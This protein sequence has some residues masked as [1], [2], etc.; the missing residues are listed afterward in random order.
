MRLRNTKALLVIIGAFSLA[1]AWLLVA[2][3][4][5]LKLTANPVGQLGA[6]I[7]M[8]ILLPSVIATLWFDYRDQKEER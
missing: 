6:W 2:L 4:L 1:V 3:S 7:A 8:G 5:S